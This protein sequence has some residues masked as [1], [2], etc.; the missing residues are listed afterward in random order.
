MVSYCAVFFPAFGGQCVITGFNARFLLEVDID[1]IP[2][3]E[4]LCLSV[5]VKLDINLKGHV[6]STDI[7]AD[8]HPGLAC[9]GR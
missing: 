6:F 3:I 9:G 8:I 5:L 7:P 1:N 2:D 4:R